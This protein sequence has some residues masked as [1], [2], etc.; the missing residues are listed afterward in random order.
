MNNCNHFWFSSYVPK[1]YRDL[2]EVTPEAMQMVK[3]NFEWV[4]ERVKV[5]WLGP[6]S[7]FLWK[8][9]RCLAYIWILGQ[10]STIHGSDTPPPL[11]P[12]VT[13]VLSYQLKKS[14]L[15]KNP[16]FKTVWCSYNEYVYMHNDIPLLVRLW[17]YS[18]FDT[19][20]VNVI[21]LQIWI[22]RIRPPK[23]GFRK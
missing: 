7:Y 3:R 15:D 2:K 22:F 20:H 16:F 17:Q 11:P 1:V 21:L 14:P 10:I 18:Q 23:I 5:R 4:S 12:F 8:A 19:G 6:L 13:L 9:S